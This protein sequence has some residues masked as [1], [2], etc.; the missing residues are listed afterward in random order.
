MPIFVPKELETL[1]YKGKL[2]NNV[3][4]LEDYKAH[5]EFIQEFPYKVLAILSH[6]RLFTFGLFTTFGCI[7][8]LLLLK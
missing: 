3:Q 2:F 5:E 4:E 1:H 8:I 7:L 6:I